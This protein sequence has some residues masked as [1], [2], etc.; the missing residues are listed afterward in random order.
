M[1]TIQI[2]RGYSNSDL[3]YQTLFYVINALLAHKWQ[4]YV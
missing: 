3:S 4:F 1:A 2:D